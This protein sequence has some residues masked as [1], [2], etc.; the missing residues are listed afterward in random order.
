MRLPQTL[1]E[2]AENLERFMIT[3]ETKRVRLVVF[4][5]LAGLMTAAPLT[6]GTRTGLLKAA[7]LARRSNTTFWTRTR[8]RMAGGVAGML[9]ADF[10]K[11]LEQTLSQR[12]DD[13]WQGYVQIFS[14]LAQRHTVTVVAGTTYLVDPEDGAVRHMSLVFGPDGELL[15]EQAAVTLAASEVGYV[16][17]GVQ[18]HVIP[19]PAGRLGVLIGNDM[20]YPEAGRLLAYAGAEMLVGLGT[21]NSTR[22]YQRQRHGL[23]ARVEENQLYGVMSFAVGYNPFTPGEETPYVGRSLLAAPIAMT[24]RYNGILVE[25]GADSTEGLITAEWNFPALRRLWEQDEAPLRATMPAKQAGR[26]LSAIY[27]RGLTIDEAMRIGELAIGPLALPEPVA[28]T[29]A[30][31]EPDEAM[32]AAM[33]ESADVMALPAL[34]PAETSGA[35]LAPD[36]VAA[37][38]VLGMSAAASGETGTAGEDGDLSTPPISSRRWPWSRSTD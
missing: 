9:K 34:A 38:V 3:A 37:E 33:A 2:L 19:T 10:G 29:A 30:L 1:D 20:L 31:P 16:A 7:D 36:D 24:P 8:A 28:A 15:G 27:S 6:K 32:T 25:M 13:L 5:Q 12:P 17:P 23:L 18:W 4:P 11:T 14:G 26:L 35:A 22:Q 21:A